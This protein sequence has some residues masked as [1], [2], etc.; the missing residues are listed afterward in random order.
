MTWLWYP[1]VLPVEWQPTSEREVEYL[2]TPSNLFCCWSFLATQG[3]LD[4]ETERCFLMS[5]PCKLQQIGYSYMNRSPDHMQ[6]DP[7]RL[8]WA[9]RI[10]KELTVAWLLQGWLK[11]LPN[12]YYNRYPYDSLNSQSAWLIAR[13]QIWRG[14]ETTT[15]AKLS[16][17]PLLRQRLDFTF[18][19]QVRIMKVRTDP[20]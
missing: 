14:F 7:P 12:S 3:D 16:S 20:Q 6:K 2:V 8:T 15:S 19:L 18:E 9:H 17:H 1:C 4:I 13:F 5:C 11:T 10:N